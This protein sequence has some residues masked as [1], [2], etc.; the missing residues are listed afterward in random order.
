[1]L[2]YEAESELYKKDRGDGCDSAVAPSTA[3]TIDVLK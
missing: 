2:M 1:M 3:A